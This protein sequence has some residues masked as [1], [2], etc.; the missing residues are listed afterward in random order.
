MTYTINL[1][2][3]IV[4]RDSDGAQVA[5]TQSVDDPLYVQYTAWVQEGNVPVEYTPPVSLVTNSHIT[6]LAF[7]RRFTQAE[8]IAIDMFS[9]DDPTAALQQRQFASA[10]RVMLADMSVALFIDLMNVDIIA[11]LQLLETYGIIGSG[12]ASQITDDP[13]QDSERPLY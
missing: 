8:K 10:L 2:T 1:V 11:G 13:I 4:T 9:I 3:G 6:V 5:P 12:R 7:R